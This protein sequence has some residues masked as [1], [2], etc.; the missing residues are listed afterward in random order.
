MRRY[1][2]ARICFGLGAGKV[3]NIGIVAKDAAL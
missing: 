3:R 1:L 2:A